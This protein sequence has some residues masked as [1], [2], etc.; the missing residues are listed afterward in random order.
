MRTTLNLNEDLVREAMKVTGIQEKTK[1]L[2]HGL[3][4]IIQAEAAERLIR[5]GGSQKNAKA[6]RRRRVEDYAGRAR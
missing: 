5:M 2:H 4:L 6:G 3:E 1:L